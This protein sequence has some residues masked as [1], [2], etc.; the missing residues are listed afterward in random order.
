LRDLVKNQNEKLL[1]KK[2][3]IAKLKSKIKEMK[4]KDAA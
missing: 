1:A 3:K 2:D 4:G